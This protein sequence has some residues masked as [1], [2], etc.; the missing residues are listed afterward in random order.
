MLPTAIP[1]EFETL[2]GVLPRTLI[3][4]RERPIDSGER[5]T[6]QTREA[7]EMYI[8]SLDGIRAI[9]FLFVFIAHAG[10]DKIVPGGFGVTIFFFLSGYLIT[11]ILR[12]EAS[13]THKIS[14]R[15]FYLRRAFRILPP[16]YIDR[17]SV[18]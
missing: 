14:L 18:V 10:L 9:A 8:P 17:K 5:P 13:R 12:L 1:D 11:S 16:M 2:A 3:Q 7:P 4:P 6:T 15:K